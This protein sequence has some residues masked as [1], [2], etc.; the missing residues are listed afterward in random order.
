MTKVIDLIESIGVTA[1]FGEVTPVE[2]AEL[3]NELAVALQNKD[4]QQLNELLGV[5][6]K[7]VCALMPAKDDEP[8]EN[9]ESE[10]DKENSS[11]LILK[12]LG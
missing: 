3:D 2:T 12:K 7:I 9:D 10:D 11:K 8:E 5:R 4:N 6:N 1:N